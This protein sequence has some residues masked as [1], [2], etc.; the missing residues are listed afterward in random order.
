MIGRFRMTDSFGVDRSKP[1]SVLCRAARLQASERQLV[2]TWCELIPRV[3][4]SQARQRRA[5][6]VEV[7]PS[8]IEERGRKRE[9]R[10]RPLDRFVEVLLTP[11]DRQRGPEDLILRHRRVGARLEHTVGIVRTSP[12]RERPRSTSAPAGESTFSRHPRRLI[13]L[14]AEDLE[15]SFGEAW[16]ADMGCRGGRCPD[17]T[18]LRR[19]RLIADPSSARN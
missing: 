3:A 9:S 16:R 8:R 15:L 17:E 5:L 14:A 13:E 7:P 12:F 11:P 19:F 18:K 2:I 4:R 1:P 6:H 10:G